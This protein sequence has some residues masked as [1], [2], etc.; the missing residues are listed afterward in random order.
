MSAMARRYER[1]YIVLLDASTSH[2]N[3]K[4]YL[5]GGPDTPVPMARAL[6]ELLSVAAIRNPDFYEYEA[7]NLVSISG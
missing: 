3:F 6:D 4:A 7:G 1:L 5:V 2:A